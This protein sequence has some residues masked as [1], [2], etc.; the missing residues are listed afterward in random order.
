VRASSTDTVAILKDTQKEDAEKALI[1]SWED[2][3][4]GRSDR[5]KRARNKFHL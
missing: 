1:K 5:A 4:A 2:R 3:E